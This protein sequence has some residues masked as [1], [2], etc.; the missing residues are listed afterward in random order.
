M[1]S[2]SRFLSGVT[3]DG[4]IKILSESPLLNIKNLLRE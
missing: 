1:K 4:N 2:V 3:S